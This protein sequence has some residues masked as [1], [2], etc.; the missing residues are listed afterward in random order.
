MLSITFIDLCMLNHLDFN[1][2]ANLVMVCDVFDVHILATLVVLQ[3]INY[4]ITTI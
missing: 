2:K 4:R 1:N 3:M